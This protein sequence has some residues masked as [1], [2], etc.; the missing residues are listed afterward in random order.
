MIP[1]AALA[2]EMTTMWLSAWLRTLKSSPGRAGAKRTPRRQKQPARPSLEVL[3]D[4]L[5]PATFLVTLLRRPGSP[6]PHPRHPLRI[7]C[8]GERRTDS[9]TFPV[10]NTA[11][12]RNTA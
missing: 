10:T 12:S 8:G 5:A 6:R 7:G 11:E 9:V 1:Q 4:R 3:E 2:K